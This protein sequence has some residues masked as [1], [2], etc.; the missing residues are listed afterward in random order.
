MA[1]ILP[2]RRGGALGSGGGA[3]LALDSL[4]ITRWGEEGEPPGWWVEEGAMAPMVD[5]MEISRWDLSGLTLV[6]RMLDARGRLKP[7]P[8]ELLAEP[9]APRGL[10]PSRPPARARAARRAAPSATASASRAR[11]ASW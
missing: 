1:R 9:A 3:G 10:P 8:R 5:A 11:P 4:A 6:T 7:L 2:A